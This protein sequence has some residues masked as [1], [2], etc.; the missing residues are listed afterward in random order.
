M[1]LTEFLFTSKQ[2]IGDNTIWVTCLAPHKTHPQ[3]DS[4]LHAE[5]WSTAETKQK[6]VVFH[7]PRVQ[8]VTEGWYLKDYY[9]TYIK[10]GNRVL[11]RLRLA[12]HHSEQRKTIKTS[13]H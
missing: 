10:L 4:E 9:Y 6:S 2:S 5:S 12:I 8:G 3:H 7:S 11:A 1:Q 13:I